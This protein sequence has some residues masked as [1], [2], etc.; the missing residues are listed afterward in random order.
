MV[1]KPGKLEVSWREGEKGKKKLE[2]EERCLAGEDLGRKGM[3]CLTPTPPT[4]FPENA[5]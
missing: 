4:S 5:V 1:A 2:V 3:T